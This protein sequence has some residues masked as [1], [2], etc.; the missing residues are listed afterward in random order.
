LG[1]VDETPD[2]RSSFQAASQH[3]DRSPRWIV[4]AA[5]V[6]LAAALLIYILRLDRVI[7]LTIDDAWYVLLAKSLATGQ[8]YSVV[9]SPSPGILPLYPPG[10]PFL[11]SIFYRLSPDFPGN[12][13]L[14]KSV[15]IAAM[16]GMGMLAYRY[17]LRTRGL[18]ALLAL[19]V[20]LAATLCPPLVFL[21]TSTVMSECVYA[22]VL[23]ATIVVVERA[24]QAHHQGDGRAMRYVLASAALA[25]YAFLVRSIALALVGA[26]FL[27]FLKERM[28][29]SAIAFALAVAL[30]A[31]PW[32][33]YSRL[34]APTSDQMR[35][36]GGHIVQPYTTQFWQ[37]VASVTKSEQI[38]AGELPGRVWNNVLEIAGKDVL[39]VV[40]A[41]LYEALRDPY[42]EAQ[43][44]LAAQAQGGTDKTTDTLLLSFVL[45]LVMLIGYVAAA[46]ARITCAEIAI[47]AL[48]LLTV[49]WPW[50]T[51][52]FVLPLA[53]FLLSY[54]AMG[55][56]SIVRLIRDGM[57]WAAPTAATAAVLAISLYGHTGYIVKVQ[58]D[59][60]D[61]P[62]WLQSFDD[63]EAMM[64]WTKQNIPQ[65][66]TLVALNPPLTH[67]YTGHKTM[68]WDDPAA[69]WDLWRQLGVRH[70]VWYSAYFIPTEAELRAY[71]QVYRARNQMGFH[72]LDL[73]PVETRGPWGSAPASAGK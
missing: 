73:G 60:L 4:I 72:V 43:R 69:K 29:R 49:L 11:L 54:F 57:I 37:R 17:L 3:V 32:M 53:P 5:L 68:A 26:V 6:G 8:G 15:S 25:S 28:T 39:R 24:V 47:P 64:A 36:Q 71:P 63:V 67:L 58:G 16:L 7:G 33:V 13:W 23:M 70:L 46:R 45:S 44:L 65:N 41:P 52:R 19:L 30:L 9:N 62:Q 38:T 35:E 61:R 1:I 31:G 66:E 59:S 20:A 18:P 42:K 51:I 2:S 55:L 22:F 34:H 48:L 27:Y 14:L 12:I 56:H 40:A 10:F 21:A 50:E